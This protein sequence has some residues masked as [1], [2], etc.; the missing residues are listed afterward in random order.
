MDVGAVDD[1]LDPAATGVDDDADA[2]ALVLGHRRK[3]DPRIGDCLLAGRHREVDEARHPAGHLRV[4]RRR[5][6]ETED[7]GGDADLE[8]GRV[9]ALDETGPGYAGDEIRP[10]RR[11]VV[12]DRHDR[13]ESGDDGPPS[14]INFRQEGRPQGSGSGGL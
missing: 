4:H 13:P 5:R 11:K 8:P 1:R 2:I 3:I 10:V 6:I 9:E 14:G 7:L 12:A